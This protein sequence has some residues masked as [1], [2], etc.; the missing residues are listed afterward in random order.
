NFMQYDIPVMMSENEVGDVKKENSAISLN[1]LADG[2]YNL[3]LNGNDKLSTNKY[4]F[5]QEYVLFNV[6]NVSIDDNSSSDN[7]SSFDTNSSE[8]NSSLDDNK[9][10]DE[11]KYNLTAP[12][13][14]LYYK[15]GTR[16]YA[17]LFDSNSSP[18]ADEN[19]T[20]SINGQEYVRNTDVN[21][22]ASIA[23]NLNVGV[24]DVEVSSKNIS[25]N[26]K[27]TVL[28]TIDGKD[29]T[30]IYR[31]GTQYY[32]R[33]VD[34]QGN[35]L[36]EGSEVEFNIKGV[37][38]KRQIDENGTAQLNINLNQGTY[39]I[40]ANNP[41]NG[42]QASNIVTVIA[43]IVENNDLVKYYRN[44]SQYVVRLLADDGNPVGANETVTFNINGV[45][46]ERTTNESGYAQLNINL[47]PGEYVITAMYGGSLVANTITVKPVLT[48]E[49]VT[50][51]YLDGTQFAA[52]L[53][54]GQGNPL[55]DQNITFNINGVFYNR[56]TDSAG[57]AHL[58][59]NL[60]A[61][62]YIITS[63]YNTAV[64]ANKI[65]INSA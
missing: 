41:E 12:E 50:M 42:E 55:S 46:Y 48:A 63:S 16:F 10:D 27:I 26:S 19:V 60:Q 54:D 38:Y 39:I 17:Y 45:M 40:T 34:G 20:I 23:V 14:E 33:F 57:I 13:V 15:N 61:G 51:K 43:K 22:S 21:G 4:I 30:K 47:Q 3:S 44:D 65:T 29:V 18:V 52:T 56:T 59:I 6:G 1:D 36:A 11:I 7:N 2:Q 24:Y 58:N 37:M 9:S 25:V 35:P 53:V 5:T 32:A 8:G 49:D 28:S 64:I 31:N 62:E